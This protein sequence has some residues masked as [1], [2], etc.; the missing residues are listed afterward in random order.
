MQRE[1]LLAHPSGA[2]WSCD[3]C[4]DFTDAAGAG[5][6]AL[7]SMDAE[8]RALAEQRCLTCNG[9][10]TAHPECAGVPFAQT[11]PDVPRAMWFVF[12]TVTTVGYGDVSPTTWQGQLFGAVVILCGVIFLAMPITA[13]GNQFARVWEERQMFLLIEGIR[14]QLMRQGISPNDVRSAFDQVDA[15]GDGQIDGSEFTNFVSKV[16]KIRSA[17]D[18]LKLAAG[19]APAM[20]ALRAAH[21]PVVGACRGGSDAR[22]AAPAVALARH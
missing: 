3:V 22:R 13:V 10:P 17:R 4:D 20:A 7:P 2:G 15:D 12:V 1:F 5:A 18:R 9:F 11:F 16:L 21:S 19:H 8:E 6:A 14:H